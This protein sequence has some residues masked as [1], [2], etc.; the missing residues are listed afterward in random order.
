VTAMRG[1]LVRICVCA[2]I[3]A[4]V[5][6]GGGSALAASGRTAAPTKT[7][8][9]DS[10]DAYIRV[11]PHSGPPGTVVRIRGAGFGGCYTVISFTDA[12]GVT[13][14]L[15]IATGADFR[16]KGQIPESA[17][18]GRGV[19]AARAWIFSRFYHRCLPS[20]IQAHV[21]FKVTA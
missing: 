5:A 6:T 3:V 16:V 15:T 18:L 1:N 12:N 10:I 21:R 2:A 4:S 14:V 17:A 11:H 8:G 9:P 19:V 20:G 7:E 13:T